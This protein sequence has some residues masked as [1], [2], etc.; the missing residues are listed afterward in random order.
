M[1]TH[2]IAKALERRLAADLNGGRIFCSGAGLVKADVQVRTRYKLTE[3]GVLPV[4]EPAFRIEAKTTGLARYTFRAQDWHDVQRSALASAEE[5]L[6]VVEFCGR[7]AVHST[8]VFLRA[9]YWAEL[10]VEAEEE[11]QEEIL[12]QKSW[13]FHPATEV[14]PRLRLDARPRPVLLRIVPYGVFLHALRSRRPHA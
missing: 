7:A 11:P 9:A 6:F 14:P 10:R 12:V 2:D 1:K 5:P 13:T 8:H 3:T 4:D